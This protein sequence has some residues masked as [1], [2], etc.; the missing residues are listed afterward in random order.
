MRKSVCLI[1]SCLLLSLAFVGI[2]CRAQQENGDLASILDHLKK[3]QSAM[4]DFTADIK[5]VKTTSFSKEPIISRGKMRFKRPD[6]M[7]VEMYPPYPTITVLDKGVLLIYFPDERVAQRYQVAGNPALAKWL[8]FIQNPIE[9]LGK[10]IWLQKENPGDI[11]L[12]VD[13]AEDL[14]IFREISIA[15]D[16]SLWMPK[17]VE[18]VEKNGDRTT[19]NYDNITI[20]TG[21]P[22]SSFKLRL[23]T[24][25]E[26]IEPMKR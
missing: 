8:L 4:S 22:A 26:I 7:W 21:I 24:D 19:I 11:V 16:T 9:T 13:P 17:R 25:V 10:K 5:Q 2:L 1:L 15:I 23:P 18:L 14:A 6:K 3:A 12:G 20:N